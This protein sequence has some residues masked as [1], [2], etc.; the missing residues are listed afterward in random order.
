MSRW[1]IQP[2]FYHDQEDVLRELASAG[3]FELTVLRPEGVI[4][5]A[6]GNPMN[7]LMVCGG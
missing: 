5:H 1:L 2:N 7:L 4:G 6:V 3:G